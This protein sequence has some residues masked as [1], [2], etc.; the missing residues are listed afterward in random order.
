MFGS[1]GTTFSSLELLRRE[2]E[3][4]DH[5]SIIKPEGFLSRHEIDLSETDKVL[6]QMNS[7]N[8]CVVGDT[9]VDEYI[10]V[11]DPLGMSQETTIVVT[12]IMENRFLGG[13][14]MVAFPTAK[15]IGAGKVNFITVTG[16]DEISG[17][18][19]NKL[20]DYGV[21]SDLMI[22]DSGL[23]P[24]NNVFAQVTRLYCV[25]VIFLNIKINKNLQD[26]M[27]EHIF[28]A[29]EEADLLI[30]S[31]FNYGALPQELVDEISSECVRRNIM[32][33]ADSQSSSQVGDVSRF[34]NTNLLTPKE[35][36]I[37][38]IEL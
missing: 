13:A 8:V 28:A 11:H 27:R 1:G 7:L 4:V 6:S 29:L 37:S 24:S 32:M 26:K 31:D 22:D 17:Y 23:L 14:G 3:F 15:G 20:N 9:I 18:I 34:L 16:N 12:P 33:V 36:E 30:F 2:T 25:L 21:S 38:I 5:S 35:R 10:S 19:K